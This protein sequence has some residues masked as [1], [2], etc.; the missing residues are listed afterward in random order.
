MLHYYYHTK[1]KLITKLVTLINVQ[2]TAELGYEIV[3]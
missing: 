3:I 1:S 2:P